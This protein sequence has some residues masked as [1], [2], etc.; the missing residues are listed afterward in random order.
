MCEKIADDIGFQSTLRSLCL[1]VVRE[2]FSGDVGLEL[3][4]KE[5]EGI[6][7]RLVERMGAR[8]DRKDSPNSRRVYVEELRLNRKGYTVTWVPM[9]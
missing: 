4:L 8:T 1:G 3:D 6:R 2:G 7:M 5:N 9:K